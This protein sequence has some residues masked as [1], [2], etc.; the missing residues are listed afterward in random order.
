[1]TNHVLNHEN[2]TLQSIMSKV[3]ELQ[4]YNVLLANYLDPE[5]AKN[6][7]VARFDRNCLFVIVENGDWTTQF[8]FQVPDLMKKLRKHPELEQISGI[9]CKTRPAPNSITTPKIPP[10]VV[11]AL[12]P[13]TSNSLLKTAKTLLDKR[14]QKVLEKIAGHLA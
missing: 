11:S 6:C 9:I 13:H 1:M 5:I 4:R 3:Q 2:K 12:S 8:R 7:K 10:R 14:L